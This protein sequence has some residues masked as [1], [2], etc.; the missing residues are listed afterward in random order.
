[1]I[2]DRALG[3]QLTNSDSEGDTRDQYASQTSAKNEL[4]CFLQNWFYFADDE[5]GLVR[6]QLEY[7]SAADA[8]K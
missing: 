6:S 2:A 1:M 7:I 5:V 8:K 3:R 4:N